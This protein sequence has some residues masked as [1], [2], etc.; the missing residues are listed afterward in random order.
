MKKDLSIIILGLV[1]V[2]TPF[3]GIP[4]SWKNVV[5][6]VIG[7]TISVFAYLLQK[8]MNNDGHARVEKRTEIFVEN[9]VRKSDSLV[10]TENEEPQDNN[11]TDTKKE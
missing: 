5:F 7:L 11:T 1:V 9:G 4:T 8:D 2:I 3:L 10:K 6:V